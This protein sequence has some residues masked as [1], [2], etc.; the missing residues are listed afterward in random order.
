M[1]IILLLMIILNIIYNI[2]G[3]FQVVSFI[4]WI[5][6]YLVST[7]LLNQYPDNYWFRIVQII[8]LILSIYILILNIYFIINIFI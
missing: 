5:L 1:Y 3:L 4:V 2:S 6:N 7:I 8:S